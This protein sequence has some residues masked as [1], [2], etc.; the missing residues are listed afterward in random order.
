MPKITRDNLKTVAGLVASVSAASVITTIV[1]Q[2]T[3]PTSKFH[4]VKLAAG[5]WVL[6]SLVADAAEKHVNDKIDKTAEKLAALK[7][8]AQ[9]ANP[10]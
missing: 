10:Q 5:A 6:S 3:T 2:N 9:Q 7:A 4:V 1:D 8:Q